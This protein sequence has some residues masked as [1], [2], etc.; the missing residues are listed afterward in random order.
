MENCSDFIFVKDHIYYY[1]FKNCLNG[2]NER[3]EY[4]DDTGDVDPD[5]EGEVE[6]QDW[7]DVENR[8]SDAHDN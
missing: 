7:G 5:S 8:L 4:L 6:A 2:F 3:D 1:L